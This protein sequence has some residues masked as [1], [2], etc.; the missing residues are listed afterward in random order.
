MDALEAD[1]KVYDLPLINYA[2]N[3][4]DQTT[5]FHIVVPENWPALVHRTAW[6]RTNTGS[7]I[8]GSGKGPAMPLVR[9]TS[10]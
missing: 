3:I 9:F 5:G 2:V 4:H 10:L 6:H 7:S 8:L 1:D